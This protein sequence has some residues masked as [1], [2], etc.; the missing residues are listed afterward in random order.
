MGLG[1]Q[2][3]GTHCSSVVTGMDLGL[4]NAA[5]R[6]VPEWLPAWVSVHIICISLV[7]IKKVALGLLS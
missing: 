4:H 7:V 1:S 6:T 3:R 2:R 5:V